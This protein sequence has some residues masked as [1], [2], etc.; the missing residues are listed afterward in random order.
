MVRP[1]DADYESLHRM[2]PV[3]LTVG[4]PREIKP[5]EK[6]VGLTPKGAQA[7]REAGIPVLIETGAGVGSNYSDEDYRR[8]GAKIVNRASEVFGRAGFVKKVKEPLPS[9]WKLL[10]EG[11]ILFSFLHLASPENRDLVLSLLRRKVTAFGIETIERGGRTLCLEPMSEIAGTLA[12]YDAGFFRRH[13][14]V[15]KGKIIYPPRF[16]EKLELL[17][18]SY[19]EIPEGL[20]PGR[21][22]IF[23]G[24]AVGRQAAEGL[25]QMGAEV[26]LVEKQEK[27]R[28]ELKEEFQHFGSRFRIWGVGADLDE[29]LQR[30]DIWIGCVHIVGERAPWVLTQE[31]LEK[32]SREKKKLILDIAVDQGGN[33]PESRSTSYEDP[34]YLDSLGNPRFGV[35]NIPSLCGRGAS[36]AIE[37]VTLSYT[38]ELVRD[39]KKAIRE[40]GEIRSGLQLHGG[41]LVNE[42]VARAHEL[43]WDPFDP[44]WLG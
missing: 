35:T 18:S 25:L 41:K 40:N 17:A 37:K 43:H 12:A 39:W 16:L 30:A 23:G 31:A 1:P 11:Q 33:F 19:P 26:D 7:L 34:L 9:E 2:T 8:A 15:E 21:V 13:V 29:A 44:G 32:H 20:P 10:R 27:R 42:A 4:V 3:P 36:Q 24:G 38:I 5:Q 14:R 28:F 22:V 6:R